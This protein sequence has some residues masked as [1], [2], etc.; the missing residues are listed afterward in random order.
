MPTRDQNPSGD[1]APSASDFLE[2]E[3]VGDEG[4]STG[5]G[6]MVAF[7]T[8]AV[9]AGVGAGVWVYF[10]GGMSVLRPNSPIPV[11]MPPAGE[12]KMRPAAPGGMTVPDRDKLVYGRLDGSAGV[13]RVERLLPPP[14]APISPPSEPFGEP[15]VSSPEPAPAPEPMP[16]PMPEPIPEPTSEPMPEPVV[17]PAPEPTIESMVMEAM[18]TPPPP[19][20][21]EPAPEPVVATPAPAPAPVQKTMASGGWRI[22][23]GALKTE[24]AAQ[25]EWARLAKAYP[26]ELGGLVSDIERADLGERGVFWRLRA[27]YLADRARA[28]A[29]CKQLAAVKVGCLIVAP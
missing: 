15:V 9:L 3:P 27:G 17:E 24:A 4:T 23:M 8:L 5:R 16:E 29:V 11:V 25:S 6:L 14:E 12:A 18:E 26:L 1:N 22:Q 7:V 21:P 10:N 2:F 20:A 13:Q 19:P 28:E